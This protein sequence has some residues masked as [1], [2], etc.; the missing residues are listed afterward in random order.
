MQLPSPTPAPLH[1]T[2]VTLTERIRARSA[3]TRSAYLERVAAMRARAPGAQRM[4]CA[5]VAH[6]FAALPAADKSRASG[7][8]RIG[9]AVQRPP[10]VGMVTA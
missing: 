6:A 2:V 7:L 9:V 10:H 1:P 8:E 5:N 3:P 4:G